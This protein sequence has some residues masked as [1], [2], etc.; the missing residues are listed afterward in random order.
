M[1]TGACV[2]ISFTLVKPCLGEARNVP[3]QRRAK[4][5]REHADDVC[6]QHV[7]QSSLSQL[8]LN[9]PM[10]IFYPALST[11]YEL[12]RN[13]G[14]RVVVWYRGKSAMERKERRTND[15]PD[16]F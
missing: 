6:L 8:S 2:I 11:V 9:L 7:F 14:I 1:Q 15:N 10:E 13:A 3:K 4:K 16:N 12:C 5:L